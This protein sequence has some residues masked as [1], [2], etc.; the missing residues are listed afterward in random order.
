M[1][2]QVSVPCSQKPTTD[3]YHNPTNWLQVLTSCLLVTHFKNILPSMSR[4]SL[5]FVTKILCIF[6]VYSMPTHIIILDIWLGPVLLSFLTI[7]SASTIVSVSSLFPE[8]LFTFTFSNTISD[9]GCVYHLGKIKVLVEKSYLV[10]LYPL[11]IIF[12]RHWNWIEI[13]PYKRHVWAGGHSIYNS[14]FKNINALFLGDFICRKCASLLT[15]QRNKVF[16][17]LPDL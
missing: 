8:L 16:T 5:K 3:Y 7:L 11:K 10:A 15:F 2:S 1:E 9:M 4:F 6:N 13:L 14:H 12:Q 17:Q